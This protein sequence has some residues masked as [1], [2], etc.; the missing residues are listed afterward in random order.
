MPTITPSPVVPKTPPP[1]ISAEQALLGAPM[2]NNRLF[3]DVDCLQAEHFY[4]PQHT[5]VFEAIE[6]LITVWVALL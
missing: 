6:Q 3:E 5:A 4:I 2:T 1:S